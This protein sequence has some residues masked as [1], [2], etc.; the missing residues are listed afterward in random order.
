MTAHQAPGPHG[1]SRSLG[2]KAAYRSAPLVDSGDGATAAAGPILRNTPHPPASRL[3][4]S[5]ASEQGPPARGG[6]TFGPVSG[7]PGEDRAGPLGLLERLL[8]RIREDRDVA[9]L[10][11]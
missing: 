1:T 5:E 6:G 4:R 2:T 7:A 11:A 3:A 8:D 9:H 10:A